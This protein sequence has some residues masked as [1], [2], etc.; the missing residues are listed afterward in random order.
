MRKKGSA[1]LV[2]VLSVGILNGRFSESIEVRVWQARRLI[3][4]RR[5]TVK[6]PLLERVSQVSCDSVSYSMVFQP[7]SMYYV[8]YL[9]SYSSYSHT[10]AFPILMHEVPMTYIEMYL[11]NG[12]M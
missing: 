3:V 9:I 1:Q 11:T 10:W 4:K 5:S 2:L 7:G 6:E 12:L 8:V